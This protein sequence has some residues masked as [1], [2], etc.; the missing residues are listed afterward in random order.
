METS[1]CIQDNHVKS[2]LGCVFQ[3]RL[4]NVH[5]LVFVAHGEHRNTYPVAVNLQL[6]YGSRPVDVAGS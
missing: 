3:C 4:G 1:R 5:R 2:V 6:L